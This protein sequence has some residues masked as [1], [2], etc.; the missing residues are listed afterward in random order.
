D[1]EA[2]CR[3]IL[4]IN[5]GR[6]LFDGA[7]EA[8]RAQVSRERQLVILLAHEETW[9]EDPDAQVLRRNGHHLTLRFDPARISAAELIARITAR[10]EIRDLYVENPPIEEIV[11]QI[12]EEEAL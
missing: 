3:R 6:I 7:L 9:V 11:A 12:Y 5:R 4:L 1:I 10:Y 8:L 2:L